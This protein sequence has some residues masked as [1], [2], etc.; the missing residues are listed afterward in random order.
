[1]KEDFHPLQSCTDVVL[2]DGELSGEAV[3]WM[4]AVERKCLPWLL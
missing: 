4:V 3:S 1:M 2:I